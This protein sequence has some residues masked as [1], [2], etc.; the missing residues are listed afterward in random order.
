MGFDQR[1]NTE[2]PRARP[3]I[4]NRILLDFLDD[5]QPYPL[6]SITKGVTFGRWWE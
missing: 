3:E 1:R 2:S 5:T 6:F 4:F